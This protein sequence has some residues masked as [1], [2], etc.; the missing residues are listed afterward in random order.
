[1]SPNGKNNIFGFIPRGGV[2]LVS[3]VVV[4]ALAFSIGLLIRCGDDA[5]QRNNMAE[6]GPVSAGRPDKITLWTCS[7]HPQIKLPNPGKCP[8]CFM[9]L[10]SIAPEE[11]G[12]EGGERRLKMTEAAA[13]LARIQ[14]APVVRRFVESDVRLA[15]SITYDE[16]RVSYITARVPG[17]LDRLYADYTGIPVEKDDRL[18][19]I[20]SPLLLGSQEELIQA[21]RSV[22]ALSGSSNEILKRTA[23]ATLTAAREKLRLYGLSAQ[24]IREIESSGAASDHLVIHAP[25][26]GI[27]VEKIAT[28]G[29]YVETGTRLYTIADLSSLWVL[30]DAY[31]SDLPWLAGGQRVEFA[32]QSLPGETFDGAIAFIDP[33]LSGKT[34]TA[35]VRT[36]VDNREGRLKPD[37]FVNGTVKSLLDRDGKVVSEGESD[38]SQAPLVIPASAPFLTGTRAVVYVRVPGGTEPVFEGREVVLG[39]RAGEHYLVRSGLEEGELVVVSGAFKIDSELQ[40]RAKPSMMNPEGGASGSAGRHDHGT[41]RS[42]TQAEHAVHGAPAGREKEHAAHE[43]PAGM[44]KEQAAREAPGVGAKEHAARGA[45]ESGIGD[46]ALEALTPL[47]GAYFEIQMALAGDRGEEAAGLNKKLLRTLKTIDMNLFEG[48]EHMRWMELSAAIGESASKGAAAADIEEG[49]EAFRLLSAVII[50]LHDSFGHGEDRN[51]YLTFCPMTDGGKGG[52]WLQPVDTVY[53][54]FYGASMLRCGSI[55]KKLPPAKREGE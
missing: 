25:A 23:T 27:V 53:N 1:M 4:I 22:N 52:Y 46:A 19:E 37:M 47:Y 2:R 32:T 31:Q 42:R 18:A 45:G 16:T 15:G 5:E 43:A 26:G 12:E 30:F 10:I 8:I 29:M 35:K 51:Y 33:V 20:Y 41:S 38:L 34:R 13:K 3:F 49:R 9:D 48:D 21:R 40:I 7:M 54:S 14:T 55:E 17:R 11:A 44:A 28:E 36:V 50:E 6:E 39:P 24:Q